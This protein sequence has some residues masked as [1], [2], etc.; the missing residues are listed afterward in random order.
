MK[1]EDIL[2][3]EDLNKLQ[4]FQ[5]KLL[6]DNKRIFPKIDTELKE[7]IEYNKSIDRNFPFFDNFN[8]DD[9]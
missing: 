1:L 6:E 4:Q 9:F 7:T 8:Y 2:T 5:N 3:T